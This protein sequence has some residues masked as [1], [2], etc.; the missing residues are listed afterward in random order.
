MARREDYVRP[1]VR[2]REPRPAWLGGWPFRLLA[3]GLLAALALAG[4]FVVFHLHLTGA[5]N[6]Q[7]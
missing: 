3:V 6:S 4:Y 2:A 5:G 7:G 1:V